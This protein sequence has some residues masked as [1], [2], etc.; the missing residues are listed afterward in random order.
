MEINAQPV[1]AV[2]LPAACDGP[3]APGVPGRRLVTTRTDTTLAV[4]D[5]GRPAAA[6]PLVTFPAP[7]PRGASGVDA[8]APGLD[9]AVFAG[10]HA[11]RGVTPDGVTRWE[12]PHGCWGCEEFH[13]TA[14]EY[15]G[16][17]DHKYPD[18][19]SACFGTDGR[20][21]WAHVR[22]QLDEDDD[23][24]GES[25]PEAWLVIDPADGTVVA[26]AGTGTY[27]AGSHHLPNP[28]PAVMGLAV[29][30]GQD[31]S[32]ALWGRLTGGVLHVERL[33]GDDR[34]LVAVG[35]GGRTF[36]T[37]G[38]ERGQELTVHRASGHAVLGTVLADVLEP[39]D[40]AARWGFRCG[41]VDDRTLVAGT[42][43]HGYGTAD[44]RHWL[45]DVETLEVRGPIRYPAV[46][47]PGPHPIGLG[48]GTWLTMSPGGEDVH[49]WRLPPA[50]RVSG[51]GGPPGAMRSA[52]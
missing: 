11:V 29:G 20:T 39:A 37:R 31:G 44:V 17:P 22:E 43:E 6:A 3:L 30:E 25:S 41:L 32:P 8:V 34:V 52:G 36:L 9:L 47:D 23:P 26:R 38:H 21:V 10:L 28:D 48:D 27:A 13:E 33:A 2:S 5:L 51:P 4:Y 45:I 12:V 7:W 46:A 16:D 40:P 50:G 18:Q 19:G 35:P 14:D 42:S 1:T 15:A 49:V 24:R